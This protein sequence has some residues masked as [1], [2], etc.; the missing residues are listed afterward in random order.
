MQESSSI[1]VTK[2]QYEQAD[3]AAAVIAAATPL[4]PRVGIVLGTGVGAL[5]DAVEGATALPFTAI[6][7][8]LPTSVL[9]HDGQLV[10]GTL[11]GVPVAVLRGRVHLYE[12]YTPQQ[13]TFPIRVFARLGIQTCIL[14]NA[15]GGLT[16]ALT[17]GSLMVISDHIGLP[18]LAGLN[19]LYGANDER[20]GPRFPAMTDAYDP[21]LRKAALSAAQERGIPLFEGI[22]AMVGGPS[23]ET[24]AELR[25]LRALGADAVGMSTVPEVIVARHMGMRVIGFSVVTNAALSDSP[26]PDVANH[27]EVL[28]AAG[29]VTE[30]LTTV[31][32]DAISRHA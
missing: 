23:F 16:P 5:A 27:E 24:P 28:R 17:P 31:V 9:G 11:A 25:L 8:L 2:S 3:E 15:A 12:G 30:R 29:A 14:T 6:P 7:H 32:C 1:P 22:Y 26:E 19:P 18:T 20:F 4:N 10:L 21:E 13:V